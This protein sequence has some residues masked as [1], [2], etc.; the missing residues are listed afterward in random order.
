MKFG[1]KL[2]L[3]K[4]WEY[5]DFITFEKGDILQVA[6]YKHKYGM[7][8]H[9]PG[10]DLVDFKFNN[11]NRDKKIE[12]YFEIVEE[13][14]DRLAELEK[15]I[16]DYYLAK[17]YQVGIGGWAFNVLVR[18]WHKNKS[19]LVYFREPTWD[20]G[21]LKFS[22]KQETTKEMF[23]KAFEHFGVDKREDTVDD[24]L[25][26][27]KCKSTNVSCACFGENDGCNCR[28]CNHS[29]MIHD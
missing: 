1:T 3:K 15:V 4:D 10:I 13:F 28:D 27:P 26:C 23:D 16:L 19:L 8:L 20:K 24:D 7:K 2:K 22:T 21:S 11:S 25:H 12:E 29:F 14:D 18:S 6:A 17:G 5:H 9:H